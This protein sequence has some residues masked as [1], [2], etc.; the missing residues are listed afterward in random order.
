MSSCSEAPPQLPTDHRGL[1]DAPV[2]A[3]DGAPSPRTSQLHQHLHAALGRLSA[4]YQT[5]LRVGQWR[6]ALSPVCGASVCGCAAPP[7]HRRLQAA[8]GHV[9]ADRHVLA[10]LAGVQR[11]LP[12]ATLCDGALPACALHAVHVD[13]A[14]TCGR[15]TQRP[16]EGVSQSKTLQLCV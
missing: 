13:G 11:H 2:F 12:V 15:G 7:A 1:V 6:R 14:G 4:P 9:A 10:V 8:V 5:H 3:A 16:S